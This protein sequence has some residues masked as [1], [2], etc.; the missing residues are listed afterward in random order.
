MKFNT[1]SEVTINISENLANRL[2]KLILK[3]LP[4][5][6]FILL[7]FYLLLEWFKKLLF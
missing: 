2:V 1:D 3:V 6:L 5:T 7:I 4:L